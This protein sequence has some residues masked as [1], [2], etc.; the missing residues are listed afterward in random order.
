MNNNEITARTN[1]KLVE[2]NQFILER[3]RGD[4]DRDKMLNCLLE[5]LMDCAISYGYEGDVISYEDGAI[6]Y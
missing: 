2:F 1:D 4:V 5:Y 3:V 6:R